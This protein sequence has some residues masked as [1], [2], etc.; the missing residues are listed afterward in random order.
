MKNGVYIIIFFLFMCTFFNASIAQ[1]DIGDIKL[2]NYRPQSIYKT[3]LKEIRKAKFPVVDMHSHDYAQTPKD[4]DQWVENM[5][6]LGIEKVIILSK[7]TG[8]AFDSIIEKYSKYPDRFDVWCGFDFTGYKSGEDWIDHAV[9]ELER[10]HSKGAKGVGELGD[11]GKGLVYS[12]PEPGVGLHIDDPQL[13]PLLKKCAELDMPINIH[14]ADPYWMYAKMDSTNDGLMNAYIW[15]ID[16]SDKDILNHNE[17]IETLENA[18]RYNPNTTFI[19]CHFANCSYDLKKIGDVLDRYDNLW[20]DNSARYAETATIPRYMQNFYRNYADK[21]LYGT[22]MGYD[23]LMYRTTF[24]ILE[25]ADE[26]FYEI[27]LF[28]YHWAL[29]GF[30]LPDDVLKKVYKINA[31]ELINNINN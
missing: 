2:K 5:D 7:Q 10:C 4:V 13:K 6:S 23:K 28:N 8:A 18:V 22:D 31:T 14:V 1:D 24:R 25:S 16:Q 11:K 30:E 9:S 26:H 3:S 27:D 29:Y 12:K 21:I 15:R 17:L 19:A 20:L